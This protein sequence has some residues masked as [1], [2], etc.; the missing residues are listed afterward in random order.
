MQ[1]LMEGFSETS[2]GQPDPPL[3]SRIFFGTHPTLMQR[4]EMAEAWKREQAGA[5]AR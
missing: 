4:I 3:W 2:L 1:K 5:T